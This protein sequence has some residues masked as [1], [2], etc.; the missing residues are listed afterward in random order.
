MGKGEKEEQVGVR[1]RERRREEELEEKSWRGR[2]ESWG[3][4]EPEER[5]GQV[6]EE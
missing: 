6:G 2:R 1:E 3:K 4:E 5:E